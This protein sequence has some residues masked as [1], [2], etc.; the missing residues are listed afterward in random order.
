MQT[1]R[2]DHVQFGRRLYAIRICCAEVDRQQIARA[3]EIADPK[4]REDSL[5][6][7]ALLHRTCEMARLRV[8]QRGHPEVVVALLVAAKAVEPGDPSAGDGQG[9]ASAREAAADP[10]GR[11]AREI[12][13]EDAVA[14]R[15]MGPDYPSLVGETRPVHRDRLDS[16]SDVDRPRDGCRSS[17]RWKREQER[18]RKRKRHHRDYPHR[19]TPTG[20]HPPR[21]PLAC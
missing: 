14:A 18:E 13:D 4:P 5:T 19:S 20:D 11:A 6:D 16:P 21:L 7:V 2:A 12:E 8:R 15:P 3:D 17:R 10:L 9:D 1:L